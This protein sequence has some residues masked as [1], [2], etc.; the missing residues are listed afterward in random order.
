MKY[1]LYIKSDRIVKEGENGISDDDDNDDSD[2]DGWM[3]GSVQ[4]KMDQNEMENEHTY[5]FILCVLLDLIHNNKVA[6]YPIVRS[7]FVAHACTYIH[8][9]YI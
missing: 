9:Y 2:R 8:I 6:Y 4:R 3:N 1:S 7:I 5:I